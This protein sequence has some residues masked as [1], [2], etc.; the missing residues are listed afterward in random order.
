MDVRHTYHELVYMYH[1]WEL[2]HGYAI[3]YSAKSFFRYRF[4]TVT[5]YLADQIQR[6]VG[7][8]GN[9]EL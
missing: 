5:E 7:L 9:N 3:E 6:G 4:S 2:D 1:R 8:E